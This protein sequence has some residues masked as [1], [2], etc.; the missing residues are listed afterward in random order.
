MQIT[1]KLFDRPYSCKLREPLFQNNEEKLLGLMADGRPIY[2]PYENN[3]G[4]V[5]RSDLDKCGGRVTGD[6]SYRCVQHEKL[7]EDE[8]YLQVSC[9]AS[10]RQN[11]TVYQR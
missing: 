5:R 9:H 2:A 10:L 11:H 8:K 7:K 1:P 6:G 4:T 3:H